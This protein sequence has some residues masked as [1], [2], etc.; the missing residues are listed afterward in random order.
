MA[1]I[2]KTKV[3]V[4]G[5]GPG[6]YVAAI[7]CGQL[8]LDTVL[9]EGGRLGG[10]CLVRGCIPS[11]ALIHAASHFEA[12]AH[13][14]ERPLFGIAL[15]APPRL[16]FAAT[17]AWKETIVDRL[18]GG[19]GAL[20]KRAKVRVVAGWAQFSD[21]KTCIV[22]TAEGPLKIQ[23]EHVILA[24]GSVPVELPF[25]RFG[26]RVISSTEA[27]S[28]PEVP[29][30]LVVVGA[31]YIGLE[32]GS[33]FAKLGSRVTIVEAQDR[34]LPLYDAKLVDPV[35]RWLERRGVELHLG[36]KALGERD[37]GLAIETIAGEQLT[38]P[39]DA[40]LVTVGRKPLTEGWGLQE[41][42]VAMDGS[43][44]RVD[45][46]CATSTR[47]VWAIGD[48][49][50]EPML[51]HKASAQGEMVAEII[52]GNNRRFD[53]QA[54]PAVCFTEPEIVTV[55]LGPDDVDANDSVI[56]LFPFAANGRAL[57]MAAAADGGFVRVI[58]HKGSHR[59]VGVQ[60]VGQHIS[61]LS[62]SFAQAIEI[63][64]VLEDIAGIIHAHPTLG[65]AFHEAALKA[66]GHA[67]HI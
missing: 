61:E 11:K 5:G 36:A 33:A 65:E 50:G 54:I 62:A 67:I 52:A 66:L 2:V 38:R 42:A 4:V 35:R 19:V 29:K 26:G 34:I 22:D 25:L 13:A 20:L 47:N 58:A 12:M 55:G 53:P 63:G 49:V 41:M 48:L 14:A 51:A 6:G 40:I 59:I 37:E 17:V 39:A 15:D 7:R 8:G 1:D 10:T 31:G 28:L 45:D 60:A 30:R 57:S 46:R 32:L 3:L 24:T 9:V 27:L 18:N 64:A 44:V 16:D 43:F 56:G 23:A 21:A